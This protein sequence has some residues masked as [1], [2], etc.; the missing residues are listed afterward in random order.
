MEDGFRVGAYDGCAV[1]GT[2]VGDT[3]GVMLGTND[4]NAFGQLLG[5]GVVGS[6]VGAYVGA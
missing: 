3:D 6:G 2:N 1:V 5:I 4:G